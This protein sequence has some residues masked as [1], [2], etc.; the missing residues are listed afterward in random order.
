MQSLQQLHKLCLLVI[1]RYCVELGRDLL[2]QLVVAVCF[3]DGRV[4]V[5]RD[6][7]NCGFE[8]LDLLLCE[9][10]LFILLLIRL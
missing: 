6:N 1:G 7:M 2:D 3:G 8:K 9:L 5:V 4:D 10:C